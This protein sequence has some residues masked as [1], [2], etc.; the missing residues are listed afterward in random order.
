MIIEDICLAQIV[1]SIT[2]HSRCI[3]A[4]DCNDEGLL[5]SVSDDCYVRIWQ[6]TGDA[7]DLEVNQMELHSGKT[8]FTFRST[9]NAIMKLKITN[10]LE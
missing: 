2:A 6:L 8:C 3:N 1:G 10:W 5:A 7:E 9:T 4:I